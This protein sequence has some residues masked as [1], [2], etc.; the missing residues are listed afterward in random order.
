MSDIT[1][2]NN[3]LVTEVNSNAVTANESSN[4]IS[5]ANN[6]VANG[7]NYSNATEITDIS[8][9]FNMQVSYFT[10]ELI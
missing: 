10:L 4:V 3:S 2:V 6:T 7:T 9:T 1:D 5:R 8:Q